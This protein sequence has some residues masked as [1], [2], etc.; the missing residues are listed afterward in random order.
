MSWN[1]TEILDI[2]W[3]DI[4]ID[5]LTPADIF[6][7]ESAM[8]VESNSPD[9]VANLIEYFKADQD[10]CDFIMMWGI[11]EW[12][13]YY[14]LADYLTKVRTALAARAA[15]GGD[16]SELAASIR[17]ALGEDV[18]TCARPAWRTGASRPT[19]CRRRSSPTRR[20]GVRDGRVLPP[21]RAAD[22]G[23]RAR[24]HRDAAGEGR[25]APR[26]VLREAPEGLPG[27]RPRGDA[28]VIDALK[29]FGMPG[30]YLLDDYE[31][32]R[33]AMEAG[34]VPDARR[35]EG[36]VRPD[37][38]EDVAHHRPRERDAR[39]HR[40]QLPVRRRRRPVEEEDAAGDD[41]AADDAQAL[42]VA[43]GPS[44]P[45]FGHLLSHRGRGGS[46]RRRCSVA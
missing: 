37:L 22:E 15:D 35:Q 36:R 1:L 3:T 41:H 45:A 2:P 29:E 44:P 17:Q 38:R 23:A 25:D 13:H 31:E 14:V 7:A 43:G 12:K 42:G 6:V 46:E 27:A 40:G 9:Y 8:L 18:A 4:D 10:V 20:A 34:R 32:R 30:A 28:A 26:D 33:A 19:T 21:P 5:A 11:E 24:E 16:V 39:V